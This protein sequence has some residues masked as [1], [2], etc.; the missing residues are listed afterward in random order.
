MTSTF[1]QVFSSLPDEL[2]KALE[3]HYHKI[4]N[5]FARGHYEAT[6]LNGGKFCEITYK[7]LEWHTEGK[8]TPLGQAPKDFGQ[9]LRS[10]ES[11][12][13]FNDSVRFHIPN[14][15]NALY[16][17]RNKRGVAHH[18]GEIDTNHMDSIFV[19]T[20][21]DWVMAELVRI[22][23]SVSIDEAQKIVDSLVTK[24]IPLIWQIGDY[25][26]VISPPGKKLTAN[27]KVLLL[28]YNAHPNAIRIENLLKWTEYDPKNKSRFRNTV[29]KGLHKQD[30]V[31]FDLRADEVII[32]PLGVNFV[33][34]NLPL[35]L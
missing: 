4:K 17:I 33:E 32:S 31:H 19:V 35:S 7:V 8:Y 2:R 1:S 30:L 20:A 29:L 23:H 25:K 24:Q 3:E 28:L 18:A 6:E 34:K 26:R 15:L 27:D 11:K 12:S 5:N 16:R 9:A 10:L 21:T 22:F 14:V 13:N